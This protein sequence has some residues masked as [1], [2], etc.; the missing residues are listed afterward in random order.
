M[1]LER[2]Y[3]SLDDTA[4][5]LGRGW[6]MTFQQALVLESPTSAAFVSE[7][8]QEIRF[9]KTDGSWQGASHVTAQLA[10]DAGGF[11]VTTRAQ[12]RFRFD[13]AGRLLWIRDR[14]GEGVTIDRDDQGR[15][16]QVANGPRSLAFTYN[17]LLDRLSKV[18]L[19]DER[20]VEY[21]YT[22]GLLTSVKDTGGKTTTYGYDAQGRLEW[23][24]DPRGATVVKLAY[25]ATT[26][27]VSD[28]WD[29]RDGRSQ[30]VWDPVRESSTVIDPRGGK[31]I[32]EYVDGVLARRIDPLGR[33]WAFSYDDQ[34][35]LLSSRDPRGQATHL[36]YNA[37]GDLIVS[38]GPNGR[39]E[40]TYNDRHDP[41]QAVNA[42]GV[43]TDFTHDAAGN[44]TGT[45]RTAPDGTTLTETFTVNTRGLVTAA[46]NARGHTSTFEHNA[47]GDLIKTTSPQG[48]VTT[49]IYD[50][51]GR[52]LTTTDPGGN[53]AG[54]T[55][56]DHTVTYTYNGN[57]QV[58]R[59]S[60]PLTGATDTVYDDAGRAVSI[61]DPR[62]RVTTFR[63]DDAGHLTSVQG[64]D[65]AVPA[66]TS[67]YDAVGNLA[68]HTDPAGR[69]V[70]YAYDLAGQTTSA[71]GPAGTFLYTYERGG[72]LA[73]AKRSGAA[74]SAT[75]T[76]TYDQRGLPTKINYGDTGT[77]DVT[78]TYDRHG[79]RSSMLDGAGTLTYTYDPFDRL[80]GVTGGG[81]P[82]YGYAYDPAGNPISSTGPSGTLSYAY[83]P[84]GLLD[85][86]TDNPTDGGPEVLADYTYSPLG[87][88]VH[89]D[90][91]NGTSW[92]R[93][94]DPLGRLTRLVH[95]QPD[96][97]TILDETYTLDPAGN[98][99][100]VTHDAGTAGER[101][102]AYTYDTLDRLTGVCY[103]T[104]D[105]EN[106]TD[107]VR[108]A[109]DPVGNRTSETRPTGTT[110]L[111]YQQ[112]TGRLVSINGPP[113]ATS[114]TYDDY[115]RLTGRTETPTSGTPVSTTYAYTEAN[116]LKS[117]T[118]DTRAE[119]FTYDG[120]GRR[121][122]TA[123]PEGTTRYAWDPHSYLLLQQAHT[124]AD[125]SPASTLA[126][127]YG[128]GLI[129]YTPGDPATA[130]AAQ[131]YAHTDP[132]GSLRAVTDPGGAVDRTSTW[133][134][135]GVH[136][137][138]DISDP[139]A[140]APGLGWAGE[141]TNPD[142]TVHLR[143]R[144]YD[145]A[146]G[147]F[148]SPDPAAS[149]NASAT[150]TYA[151]SNPMTG[152]DP[153]GLFMSGLADN[154]RQAAPMIA[155]VAGIGAMVFPIAAPVLGPIAIAAGLT[156]AAF[157]AYDAY[158]TCATGKGACGTAILNAA[159]ETAFNLP[160]V[161][162]I[163][164]GLKLAKSAAKSCSFSGDTTV[165]MADGTRKP[166]K[167]VEVGDK[168]IATD[169]ET[170]DQEAKAVEHVWIHEDTVI[171][172]VV[173]GE[174]ITTTDDHPFWSITDQKFERADELGP[175]EQVLA[176][177][178]EL[179]TVVG[180]TPKSSRQALAYN[181][182]VE[183]IHTYHVGDGAILVHNTC[184]VRPPNLS[185][186]GAGR[187]GAFNQAKRDSGV[188]TSM[189][190]TRT[191]PNRDRRGVV[192]PGRAYEF[193]LPAPGGGQRTVV[194]RED[195]GGHV[196][197]DD[198]SQNRGPHFNT[199]SKGH[200]DY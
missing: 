137:T 141:L 20:T 150:Y 105:C 112:A 83:T 73:T 52:V 165:L 197:R 145:P 164:R 146:S 16:S 24:K 120:D 31:W 2:T 103:D 7:E 177:D 33:A 173:D 48:R 8:G 151:G 183:G 12:V 29:P 170:G 55:P 63:Y 124:P 161:G 199:E 196:Y 167:D 134:P 82:S 159:A 95:K 152:A 96:D 65:P 138:K 41:L 92:D 178:G 43:V 32:D 110:T 154:I 148:T 100:K 186:Q 6:S 66:A 144:T 114:L 69:T 142:E 108:W 80:T 117:A 128:E 122:T 147:Q 99:F 102:D 71:T 129:G 42:K 191:L 149:T 46:T 98:P 104:A 59:A 89:A 74:A 79:N 115:G 34:L 171:D 64:P 30:F 187:S 126:Y 87:L 174:V 3:N 44:L 90:L 51:A 185:P 194:V 91:G 22:N 88:P 130:A 57:D 153:Y 127:Q 101:V 195:A 181:L 77:P 123:T 61:T 139:A 189:S 132:Q 1:V 50:T 140:P 17:A 192:Q 39:V 18:T 121:L 60:H 200:Y 135:Y 9:T 26:G 94:Y 169:P 179:L 35:R 36:T 190:P 70:S 27:R 188:P 68:T 25:D 184:G 21:G 84:D 19:P 14:N 133:E 131:S 38:N 109:Y 40:T 125:G 23:E 97:T 4:G 10:E 53:A 15:V 58:T 45:T 182:T 107:Y 111:T 54:A 78:Y 13:T 76:F 155:T 86:V 136:R 106:A 37:A 116:L 113:G 157:A 158:N 143:A 172:L 119:T 156:S 93:T 162:T 166:I 28:Q 180:L 11:T 118:T 56:A 193:D 175:G 72:K 5:V 47:A 168:V 49:S 75:T 176:N 160:G 81:R 62:G 198:P 163:G 67:T 85:T